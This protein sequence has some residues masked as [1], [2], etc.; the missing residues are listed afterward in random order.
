M[1]VSFK[2]G[3][4]TRIKDKKQVRQLIETMKSEDNYDS[5]I[6][7]LSTFHHIYT[8]DK[9]PFGTSYEKCPITSHE[10]QSWKIM[11]GITIEITYDDS[12][13]TYQVCASMLIKGRIDGKDAVAE[14]NNYAKWENNWLA[15]EEDEGSRGVHAMA[16]YHRAE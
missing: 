13:F 14:I 5:I 3:K 10:L 8:C 1:K 12:N 11:R 16:I 15:F 7:T 2:V 4:E 9:V 6:T